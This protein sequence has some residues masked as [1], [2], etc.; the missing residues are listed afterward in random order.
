MLEYSHSLRTEYDHGVSTYSP[1]GRLFQVEYA[2]ESI[3]VS[4]YRVFVTIQLGST[5]IGIRTKEGV[6]L[7]VEKR[8]SSK[9][10]VPSR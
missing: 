1:E 5:A 3:K 2:I 4:V 8:L 10:I 6:V 7:A 9:L